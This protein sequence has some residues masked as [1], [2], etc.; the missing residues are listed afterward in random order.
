MAASWSPTLLPGTSVD[1]VMEVKAGTH[2][3]RGHNIRQGFLV[4]C[5]CWRVPFCPTP[6]E[7]GSTRAGGGDGTPTRSVLVCADTK[8]VTPRP[9]SMR[10]R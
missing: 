2:R 9:C 10:Y 6:G 3:L 8:K 7:A 5:G 4:I 1:N